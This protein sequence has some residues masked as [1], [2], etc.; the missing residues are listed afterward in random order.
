[1]NA[2]RTAD[3]FIEQLNLQEHPE[4]GYYAETYRASEKFGA[5]ALPARF[6]GERD[7]ATLIYFLLKEKQLNRLH[8]IKSDEAWHFYYGQTCYIHV[9]RTD[10][11]YERASLGLDLENGE[12]I[13]Y[14][15]PAGAWFCAEVPKGFALVGCGVAPGFDFADLEMADGSLVERFPQHKELLK[16]L[17]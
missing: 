6:G 8:R 11:S 13:Q 7:L 2:T 5:E 4:G 1:M 9:V 15:V 16:R 12:T 10:G 14:I 17:I 3:Y